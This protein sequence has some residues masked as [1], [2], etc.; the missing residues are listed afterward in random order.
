MTLSPGEKERLY[1][2]ASKEVGTCQ[3]GRFRHEIIV[4]NVEHRLE[5]CGLKNLAEY[6]DL[7][8]TSKEEHDHFLS[9]VTIHT[10]SWFREMPHYERLKSELDFSLSKRTSEPFTICS[11]ACSTGQEV[12][13]FALLLEQMRTTRA[14][15]EYEIQGIDIDPICIARAQKAIYPVQEINSIPKQYRDNLMVGSG[16]TNGLFTLTHAIRKRTRFETASLLALPVNLPKFD[17]VICRNVLIYFSQEDVKKIVQNLSL[18]LKPDGVLV[19]GHSEAINAKE[20][21]LESL[22]N[23]SYGRK[24]PHP[25]S[26]NKSSKERI[27]IVDDCLVTQKI[28]GKQL[29]TYNCEFAKS[30][31]EATEIL[32]KSSFDLITLDINMP[33]LNGA[34]WLQTQRAKGLR[35][36][37]VVITGAKDINRSE[38]LGALENGAQDFIDK[39]SIG[40][41]TLTRHVKGL[42]MA[43]SRSK[44]PQEKQSR[45]N[46][47]E[48][49]FFNPNV[50][51][52][53]ASTGGTEALVT[54]L[55]HM[56]K[57]CPPIIIVQHISPDFSKLFAQ[58]LAEV[59]GLQWE[60]PICGKLLKRGSLYLASG[61]YHIGI[62]KSSSGLIITTSDEAPYHHHRPSVDHLFSSAAK[63]TARFFGILLTGM[64]DDGAKG[65][66][67][68]KKNGAI[69]FCQDEQSSVIFGMPKEAI[70][71]GAATIVGNLG[72]I[73]VAI[74]KALSLGR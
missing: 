22:G 25:K 31:Y 12:Y 18:L 21:N 9:A 70:A 7:I 26:V 24:N 57:E 20:H 50:I 3:D 32:R 14:N 69:T 28:L 44:S 30:A 42:L 36:P 5:V 47:N 68:M 43:F 54:L 8:Q 64:G 65:L 55:S 11:I 74:D 52:I 6:L 53:G 41:N 56:P 60:E 67:E 27:L 48:I 19:L 71:L 15:F 61:D 37:V 66:L 73:R 39:T 33:G 38:V 45:Q 23:A 34:A 17:R 16:K 35:T 49:K 4:S 46:Y 2:F 51:L 58:R 40:R 63:T 13:S 62:R 1:H 72:E 10:T 59:S 29:D